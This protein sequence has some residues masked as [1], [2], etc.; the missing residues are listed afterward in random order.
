V[1]L[2][3][4]GSRGQEEDEEEDEEVAND[5][6]D[7]ECP[8]PLLQQGAEGGW[9][10]L[11]LDGSAAALQA[12]LKSLGELR[13]FLP[14][15][16]VG[17]PEEDE[18]ADDGDDEEEKPQPAPHHRDEGGALLAGELL[19]ARRLVVHGLRAGELLPA[20]SLVAGGGR[21]AVGAD[22][23]ALLPEL[24]DLAVTVALGDLVTVFVLLHTAD[25][26]F[27]AR[28]RVARVARLHWRLVRLALAVRRVALLTLRTLLVLAGVGLVDA[29]ALLAHLAGRA[30][31]ALAGVGLVAALADAVL[32]VAL[33]TRRTLHALALGWRGRRR[34][35]RGRAATLALAIR[36]VTLLTLRAL[37]PI[38]LGRRGRRRIAVSDEP[39]GRSVDDALA[40]GVGAGVQLRGVPEVAVL[41][42]LA[43]ERVGLVGL[44]L[45]GAD[46]DTVANLVAV[47]G[48]VLEVLLGDR[49]LGHLSRET[50]EL[51]VRGAGDEGCRHENGGQR[52]QLRS[53][54][55]TSLVV[56]HMLQPPVTETNEVTEGG[57]AP[58][59]ETEE[60]EEAPPAPHHLPEA[61]AGGAGGADMRDGRRHGSW[62]G[63]HGR[64]RRRL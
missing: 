35:R 14:F 54:S 23:V 45:R 53:H 28:I 31:D 26:A 2:R 22:L 47:R 32:R 20:R 17:E 12:L 39:R 59:Q 10:W 50:A 49:G 25:V 46:A 38:A 13:P 34:R 30:G 19:P 36:W 15:G 44:R 57:A 40:H 52:Q 1:G 3:L 21:R 58:D 24:L 9:G 11:L 27:A 62:R 5:E 33:A 55:A 43:A 37:H 18:A 48:D 41:R 61:G 51:G 16:S 8:P 56:V 4:L 29:D 60:N 63:R 42:G 6:G 7:E 64:G